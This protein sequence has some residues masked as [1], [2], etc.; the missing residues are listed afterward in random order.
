MRVREVGAPP[1]TPREKKM[2]STF[3]KL[4]THQLDLMREYYGGPVIFRLAWHSWSLLGRGLPPRNPDVC[5]FEK[6]AYTQRDEGSD[7]PRTDY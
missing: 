6:L 5:E 1:V 3:G 7:P 4:W 2:T